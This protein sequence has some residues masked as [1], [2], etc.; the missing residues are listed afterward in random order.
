[1][2]HLPF[3]SV[4][5]Y[6]R[7]LVG[8]PDGTNP[9]DSELLEQF[10]KQRDEG[11]FAT[12]LG[13]HGP[14][15]LG[16][17]REVLGDLH[18]AEDAFQATFLVLARKAGSIRKQTSLGPWLYR[19]AVNVA[20]TARSRSVQRRE[21]E[22]EAAA[23]SQRSTVDATLERDW[24]LLLHEEVG[25]L[26]EKYRAPVVLCYFK[27]KTNEEA[28]RDL[29]WPVG[30]VKG[31]LTRARDLLRTRLTRRGLTLSAAGFTVALSHHVV[32]AAVSETLLR[33]T[34]AAAV[35]FALG[36][37]ALAGSVSAHSNAAVQ[38]ATQ[39][40]KTMGMAKATTALATLAVLLGVG[41]GAG[42]IALSARSEAPTG[43]LA[44]PKKSENKI[45]PEAEPSKSRRPVMVAVA[46]PPRRKPTNRRPVEMKARIV[47]GLQ[48]NL[49]APDPKTSLRPD[50]S[51]IWSFKLHFIYQNV[52]KQPLKLD[53][54]PLPN[55]V[56][57]TLQVTGPTF[58]SSRFVR[59]AAEFELRAPQADD[60]WLLQPGR[61]MTRI[62][63]FPMDEFGWGHFY[64]LEPGRYRLKA[65]YKH[66]RE[67]NSP[68]AKGSWTGTVVSNELPVEVLPNINDHRGYGPVRGLCA[69]ISLPKKK[70]TVGEGIKGTYVIHNVSKAELTLWHCGFWPNHLILVRD[71]KG[72]E[73][74]LTPFGRQCRKAFAPAGERGKNAPVKMPSGK[75]DATEG[76][77]DLSRL[78]DLTRPD[79]YTVQYVYEEEH[80][81]GWQGRL[82][83]NVVAF[84]VAAP[85]EKKADKKAAAKPQRASRVEFQAVISAKVTVP[86]SAQDSWEVVP[87]PGAKVK[88]DGAN[89]SGAQPFDLGLRITNH[90]KEP[91]SFNLFDTIRPALQ[92]AGGKVFRGSGGHNGTGKV[93]PLSLGP[94]EGKTV[95][96]RARL[97]WLKGGKSLRL[98]W[99][100]GTFWLWYFDGLVPGKYVVSF[101][102]ENTKGPFFWLGKA[103]SNSAAF[104]LL[105]R[106]A[107]PNEGKTESNATRVQGVDFQAVVQGKMTTPAL[108]RALAVDLGLRITNRGKKLLHFN[109]AETLQVVLRSADG[110]MIP[111]KLFGSDGKSRSTAVEVK[112]GEEKLVSL[113]AWLVWPQGRPNLL[114]ATMDGRG[115][116]WRFEVLTPGKYRLG[117]IYGNTKPKK[118]E[119]PLWV[120]KATT[121]DV[122][123]EIVQRK[124]E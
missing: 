111:R 19:V 72:R 53:M 81:G 96:W 36:R 75:E 77:Y 8:S 78:Y 73:P 45:R 107:K 97:E 21:H 34:T 46:V 54:S 14:L 117:I 41:C 9:S 63:N 102:Y 44:P 6:V 76:Q 80:E 99:S 7:F 22:R 15:V 89:L 108:G 104:E 100:D 85:K 31:R 84:N 59:K 87:G 32:S 35:R 91:L 2:G 79:R 115:C 65:T 23:M 94:G 10:V 60:F 47:D 103:K 55:L 38:L 17:C 28:A 50:G 69:K 98:R 68:L 49:H 29:G 56:G 93:S 70:F 30:T 67:T 106:K 12:L 33:A 52:S 116:E 62:V 58:R 24:Q 11:A 71:G 118:G 18:A 61:S 1:M 39:T 74:P 110:K 66:L 120:G 13:R 42:L 5:R 119:R 109:M 95:R 20:K 105:A 122:E 114:L 43:T 86:N 51:N 88:M 121:Q 123:F 92:S 37:A 57:T 16:V 26:P 113:G 27:G 64:L 82:P 4:V 83:S 25:R 90:G 3:N 124:K 112:A 48:L 40:S 101:T